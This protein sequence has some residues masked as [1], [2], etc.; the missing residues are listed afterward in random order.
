MTDRS[1][2]RQ[3]AASRARIGAGIM[4][5]VHASLPHACET[6]RHVPAARIVTDAADHEVVWIAAADLRRDI[7]T[8]SGANQL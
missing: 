8:I 6:G 7:A 5:P 2:S 4:S 1:F 3:R